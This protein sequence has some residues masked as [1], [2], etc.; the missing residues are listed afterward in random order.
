MGIFFILVMA[1]VIGI[2]IFLIY[3]YNSKAAFYSKDLNVTMGG[4]VVVIAAIMIAMQSNLIVSL[5]MVGALSVVRFRNAIKNPLDLLYVFWAVSAGIIV[6]VRLEVLAIVLCV[7]MTILLLILDAV[8]ASK[9][10]AI[11]IIHMNERG[12]VET[13]KKWDE[14]NVLLEKYTRYHKVKSKNI[15]KEETEVI[16]E[17]KCSRPDEL[18][19]EIRKIELIEQINYLEYDGEFRG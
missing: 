8:P 7:I 15:R 6:G 18:L 5:G 17:V 10:P 2:Y 12:G 13:G 11:L 4:M 1:C 14:I 19:A 16:I 3:K 9:A